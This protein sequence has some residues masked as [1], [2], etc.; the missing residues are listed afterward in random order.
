MLVA[1]NKVIFNSQKKPSAAKKNTKNKKF[2]IF[3]GQ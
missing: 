1:K 2:L 3:G